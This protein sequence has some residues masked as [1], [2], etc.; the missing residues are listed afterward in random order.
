MNDP[1]ARVPREVANYA[2]NLLHAI[3][4]TGEVP[5]WARENPDKVKAVSIALGEACG[6]SMA[7]ARGDLCCAG[8]IDAGEAERCCDACP[9]ILPTIL[10]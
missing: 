10:I 6:R 7:A 1:M 5:D 3:A 2:E 4:R 8:H 9:D